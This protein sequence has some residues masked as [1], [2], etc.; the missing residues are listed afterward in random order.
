MTPYG[1]QNL[2]A[3]ERLAGVLHKQLHQAEFHLCQ[4]DPF[5]VFLQCA[6][7]QIQHEGRAGQLVLL[8]LLLHA[9]AAA[10]AHQRVHACRQLGRGEGL[11]HIVVGAGHQ[12]RHLVHFLGAGRQ[13]DDANSGV[14]GPQTA[15]YLK[16]I[17]AGQHHVQQRYPD[18]LLGL[19]LFQR[20]LAA[21]GLDDLVSGAAQID[22]DKATDIG[23]I[24]QYQ[25]L[26]HGVL[27]SFLNCWKAAM[28]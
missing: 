27:L 17:D 14:V 7:P 2:L 16:P 10:A 5:A 13:H 11:C 20:F 15:A 12:A 8:R 6:V 18:I 26:S 24:L 4:L 25:Y 9:A 1:V 19:Q 28:C 21:F 22:D 23:F 3:A